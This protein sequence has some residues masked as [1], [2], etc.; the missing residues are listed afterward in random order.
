MFSKKIGLIDTYNAMGLEKAVVLS[1]SRGHPPSTLKKLRLIKHKSTSP[2]HRKKLG[3]I[4]HKRSGFGY[5]GIEHRSCGVFASLMLTFPIM[6]ASNPQLDIM[7]CHL[8]RV[9]TFTNKLWLPSLYWKYKYGDTMAIYFC[10]TLLWLL[11]LIRSTSWIFVM[12][13]Q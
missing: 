13:N 8:S 3:L 11:Q 5:L 7:A 12:H 9:C 1:H 2:V 6:F 10:K 4:K